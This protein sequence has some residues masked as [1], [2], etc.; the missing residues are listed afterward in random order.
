MT[1]PISGQYGVS[2]EALRP[3]TVDTEVPRLLTQC[4]ER[5]KWQATRT[6]KLC[7]AAGAMPLRPR[8]SFD[9]AQDQ[10]YR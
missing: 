6:C 8:M 2:I 7:V 4:A 9:G 5:A 1:S 10:H 3:K